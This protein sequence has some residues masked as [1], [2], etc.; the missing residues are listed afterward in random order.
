[1]K[2]FKISS[3]FLAA[4][5]MICF[6]G[7]RTELDTEPIDRLSNSLMFANPDLAMSILA[8]FYLSV[9]YGQHSGDLSSYHLLD[10]ANVMYGPATTTDNERQMPRNF[11]R[12]YDYSLVRRMNQFL[13]GIRSETARGN[14]VEDVRADME[15]QCRFLRAW[16]Y[17][18]M[19]RSLGG[20]PIV[21]DQVFSYNTVEDVPDMRIPRSTEA[22]T[23]DYIIKECDEII[24]L[25]S[26]S[27]T[28]NS[29]IANR[30]TAMMLKARAAVYAGSI[31]NYGNAVTPT[32]R[33]ANWE[34]GIPR[35]QSEGYYRL[36]LAAATAVIQSSPYQLQTNATNPGLAF[37]QATSVKSGNTEVIW[38]FD[39]M[40]P[41]QVTSF[42]SFA[43][44]YSHRDYTEGNNLGALLNLV[45]A[46]EN[47]DGS[48]K[49][50]RTT[51]ADGSYVFYPTADA[52]FI[53]K[54]ARLWGTIIWPGAS[55]RGVEVVLQAG[56]LN[57]NGNVW[58][59]RAAP[60]GD[61]D[62][63]GNLITSLNG[64][65]S[66][67]AVYVNKTGFLVRKF[68]DETAN[69]GLNPTFSDMWMPRFRLAEAYLIAAEAA[70]ELNDNSTAAVYLNQIRDRG[71]IRSLSAG[72]ITL[73]R[74]ANE[75]RVEFAFE[76]HRYWDMKRWRRAH[77]EW[78]GVLNGAT[79]QM[80][81][82]FPYKVVAAGHPNNGNWAFVKQPSYKRAQT[83]LFFNIANYYATIEDGWI[84]NN[85]TL[86]RNPFQ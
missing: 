42:T 54:D 17:F 15:A 47:R 61:R 10:E 4:L 68:L 13:A 40:R 34:A 44:P 60:V 67:S 8:D 43:M 86:I 32:S 27:K 31:A 38:A 55:Y 22:E 3:A 25:L 52:P 81:A 28:I 63:E 23:Y 21:G 46:F 62:T 57:R 39:R 49:E 72:E 58:S 48:P 18:C 12:I 5:F 20:M 51:N 24:P 56:Q 30:W 19:A 29:S 11:Y 36:A 35:E 45:E 70:Y 6:G 9:N 79:S 82:L 74:I 76:D 75:Y 33:T 66:N 1:M 2:R 69:A 59:L 83:P 16:Y 50:I 64:P 7:C 37:Y 26:S 41:N 73:D 14:I 65:V 84:A 85:P 53:N 78:N 71:R 77:I 80:Y